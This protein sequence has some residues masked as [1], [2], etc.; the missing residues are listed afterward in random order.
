M[1]IIMPNQPQSHAISS[2]RNDQ[3]NNGK[4]NKTVKDDYKK[5][6]SVHNLVKAAEM[7]HDI[8]TS[9]AST[10]ILFLFAY[11]SFVVSFFIF[12]ICAYRSD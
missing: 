2:I 5:C 7:E 8:I 4:T 11:S 9:L 12:G 3:I 6:P 10:C 1:Y